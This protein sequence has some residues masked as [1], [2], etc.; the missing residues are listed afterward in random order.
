MTVFYWSKIIPEYSKRML[1]I[2][3]KTRYFF[4]NPDELKLELEPKHD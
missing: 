4:R 2:S 1:A 3:I